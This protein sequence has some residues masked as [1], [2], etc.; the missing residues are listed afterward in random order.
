M[1]CALTS[2]TIRTFSQTI[3][4]FQRKEKPS[5]EQS[6]SWEAMVM[7]L[8]RGDNGESTFNGKWPYEET[9][10]EESNEEEVGNDEL[11]NESGEEWS[12]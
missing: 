4:P 11:D 6:K 10:D 12:D 3:H 5:E 9:A 7:K 8:L 2:V 1:V